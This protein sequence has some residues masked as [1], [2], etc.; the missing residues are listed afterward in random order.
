MGINHLNNAVI[1]IMVITII[2]NNKINNNKKVYFVHFRIAFIIELL[3]SRRFSLAFI[4]WSAWCCE[5]AI[6]INISNCL[7]DLKK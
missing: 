6:K 2:N 4:F 7:N 1:V 5:P 3:K